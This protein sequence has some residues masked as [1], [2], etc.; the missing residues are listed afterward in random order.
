MA[1]VRV[2][3]VALACVFAFGCSKTVRVKYSQA[4]YEM[5][6]TPVAA[7]TEGAQPTYR[8]VKTV[9][10]TRTVYRRERRINVGTT[11]LWVLTGLLLASSIAASR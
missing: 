2:V 9:V 3:L 4:K 5:R 8:W 10:G 6:K 7:Q 11:V 1:S